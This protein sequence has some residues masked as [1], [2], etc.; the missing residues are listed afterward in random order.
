MYM[1]CECGR[2]V[3]TWKVRVKVSEVTWRA[4]SAIKN[5]SV[6]CGFPRWGCAFDRISNGRGDARRKL[7]HHGEP[8][9]YVSRWTKNKERKFYHRVVRDIDEACRELH[10]DYDGEELYEGVKGTV[11]RKRKLV[12][13]EV[14]FLITYTPN[15]RNRDRYIRQMC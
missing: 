13:I 4:E 3:C 15:I 14:T 7:W 5:K 10:V 12:K 6:M 8:K 1:Q 11:A 9:R 2:K